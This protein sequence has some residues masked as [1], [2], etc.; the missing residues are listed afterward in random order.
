MPFCPFCGTKNSDDDTFCR[1][2]GAVLG[3]DPSQPPRRKDDRTKI[4]AVVLVLIVIASAFTGVAVMLTKQAVTGD[5][6]YNYSWDYGGQS[7]SYSLTVERSYFNKMIDSDID[8]SGT[9][10]SD[11]Y[12]TSSGVTFAVSDYIVVDSYIKK[13]SDDLIA[14]YKE[15][16]S[17]EMTNDD[18]VNF[19]TAF[20]QICISYDYDEAD[21]G[22]EYWRFPLETL[23]D[24][25]GDC[26]DTSILLAALIDAY[27]LKGGIVLAPGHAMCAI[28]TSEV[29]GPYEN[30]MHSPINYNG[31][32]SG[33]DYYLME[34]TFNEFAG[35]G[36]IV[37]DYTLAYL[38]LYLG[39]STEYYVSS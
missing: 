6:T 18:Y 27:G 35:I 9:I 11:R 31:G 25:T 26:E 32:D 5:L 34:T 28:C 10:S 33:V 30:Q 14:L 17:T 29:T 36:E 8:R 22:K 13:V 20:V 7:F 12:T 38:H 15:K 19:I 1:S 4:I 2:C 21:N 3:K 24:K 39:Y 37:K 16:I 23:C